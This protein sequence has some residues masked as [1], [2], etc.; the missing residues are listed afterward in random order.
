MASRTDFRRRN[1]PWE[2][3]APADAEEPV[4]ESGVGLYG[5]LHLPGRGVGVAQLLDHLQAC[6]PAG[7]EGLAF[8]DLGPAQE[9]ALVE[10]EAHLLAVVELLAGLDLLGH[11]L[12][13]EVAPLADGVL[14]LGRCQRQY[15]KFHDRDQLQQRVV[16]LPDVVVQR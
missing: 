9:V 8:D 16:L 6:D 14:Q 13:V 1:S 11:Q 10:V 15:V 2:A 4:A 7:G 3:P 12:E 5:P